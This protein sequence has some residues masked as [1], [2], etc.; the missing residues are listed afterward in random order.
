VAFF[1]D[2]WVYGSYP[3]PIP[4]E[5]ERICSENQVNLWSVRQ[6]ARLFK[7]QEDLLEVVRTTLDMLKRSDL[8]REENGEIILKQQFGITINGGNGSAININSAGAHATVSSTYERPA[9]FDELPRL[10]REQSL[11]AETEA[12]LLK[13]AEDLAVGHKEG[14]FGQAYKDFMQNASNHM[15]VFAPVISGLSAL[16]SS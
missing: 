10:I 1:Q 2:T 16:L 15:S 11:T 9:I 6:M 13:S 14:R 5:A 7:R 4:D 8:Y 3:S 12:K